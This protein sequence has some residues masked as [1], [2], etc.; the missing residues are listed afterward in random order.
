MKESL[1]LIKE[2]KTRN[3]VAKKFRLKY[4]P[5]QILFTVIQLFILGSPCEFFLCFML[6]C[7]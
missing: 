6:F 7:S 3:I 2:L 5:L 4:V 1:F